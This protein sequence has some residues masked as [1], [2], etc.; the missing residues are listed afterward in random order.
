MDMLSCCQGSVRSADLLALDSC[1]V[2]AFM[3]GHVKKNF[4]TCPLKELKSMYN[5][6][7]KTSILFVLLAFI[8]YGLIEIE[9]A[10]L[11]F[12]SDGHV[13]VE[14]SL[15]GRCINVSVS[16]SQ[17][18][19]R[20]SSENTITPTDNHCGAC[21]DIPL[22]IK[23]YLKNAV[24]NKNTKSKKEMAVHEGFSANS[25]TIKSILTDTDTLVFPPL[26]NVVLSCLSTVIRLI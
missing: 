17:S 6:Y 15:N 2:I 21:I 19:P 23:C 16:P 13:A 1:E 22:L 25:P 26:I 3:T 10:V 14:A 24:L 12:G 7:K 11:C 5:R 4:I 20:T 18:T 8:S 9:H